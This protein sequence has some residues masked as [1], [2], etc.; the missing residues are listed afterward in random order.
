MRPHAE[1]R[2]FRGSRQKSGVEHEH[3]VLSGAISPSPPAEAAVEG[4]SRV[5]DG[6][7]LFDGSGLRMMHGARQVDGLYKP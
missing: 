5:R 1:H 6:T 7:D 4:A 2:Q 3:D